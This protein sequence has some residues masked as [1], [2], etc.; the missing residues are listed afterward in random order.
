M[1]KQL[2]TEICKNSSTKR[3]WQ[4]RSKK[5]ILLCGIELTFIS[6]LSIQFTREII[7]EK[8]VFHVKISSTEQPKESFIRARGT[9]ISPQN[10]PNFV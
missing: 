3:F 7:D 4:E 10:S 6:E 9:H 1:T 2:R 8:E 5:R